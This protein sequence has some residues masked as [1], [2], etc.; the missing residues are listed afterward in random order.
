MNDVLLAEPSAAPL[1]TQ[2]PSRRWR[3]PLAVLVVAAL[4]AT[5]FTIWRVADSRARADSAFTHHQALALGAAKGVEAVTFEQWQLPFAQRSRAALEAAARLAFPEQGMTSTYG[6]DVPVVRTEVIT[7]TPTVIVTVTT[8]T[9][10]GFTGV[11]AYKNTHDGTTNSS[12]VCGQDTST[13]TL[14]SIDCA[15]WAQTPPTP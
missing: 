2:I 6:Q 8:V 11:I 9:S 13:P 12:D 14:T 7:W 10:D 1:P 3:G 4:A 15:A 5:G